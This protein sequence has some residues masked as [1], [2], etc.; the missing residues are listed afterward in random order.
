MG[1]ACAAPLQPP[2]PLIPGRHLSTTFLHGNL[3]A[4]FSIVQVCSATVVAI[5]LFQ[6]I[7][8]YKPDWKHPWLP[9]VLF[10]SGFPQLDWGY[11]ILSDGLGLA[12]AFATAWY[13]A[14]LIERSA[15]RGQTLSW[16]FHLWGLWV[17]SSLAFLARETGWFAVVTCAYLI[18]RRRTNSSRVL[19]RCALVF[20][21]L[22]VGK[23]AHTMYSHH[24]HLSGVPLGFSVATLLTP[25]YVLDLLIKTAVCFNLAW[26]FAAVAFWRQRGRGTP[27]FVIG[28]TIAAVLYI[29]LGYAANNFNGI[30]YPL[31]MS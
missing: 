5:L 31:R 2:A 14:T 24:F 16:T 4:A 3:R 1:R 20:L 30:G 27:E 8:R 17:C 25:Y 11:H 7:R 15:D 21:V 12:T 9:S 29:G 28:W 6:L 13:A 10:V 22:L 18:S 23:I 26:I 19:Y